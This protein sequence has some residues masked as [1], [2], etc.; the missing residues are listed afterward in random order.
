[1]VLSWPH[2]SLIPAQPRLP[3]R[4]LPVIFHRIFSRHLMHVSVLILLAMA[5]SSSLLTPAD[6]LRDPDVWWHLADA[7]ILLT[8]HH[9]IR[10]EPYAFTLAGQSWINPEWLSEVP[11]WLAYNSAGLLGIFL[12][13][14]L[15]LCAN[16]LF[17]YWRCMR[18][19][20]HSAA[21]F[22]ASVMGLVLMT[23]NT[24][25]RTILPAYLALGAEMALLE[26]AEDGKHRLLWLLPPLFCV[27]I[28]L[29]GSALVGLFLFALYIACG[30]FS[31]SMG[32]IVQSAWPSEHRRRLLTIFAASA[33]ALFINPYGWR[34]VWNP[35]DMLANQGL[36]QTFAEEWQPLSLAWYAG[37]VSVAVIVLLVIAN[38]L[39][40]RSWKIY[41]VAFVVYAWYA[42][43]AHARFT[44]FAA[45]I[46]IPLLARESAR[47]FLLP[48]DPK[49]MPAMNALFAAA[50]ACVLFV[51]FPSQS[52]LNK[53]M[54]AM[55]PMQTIA[56]L[57]PSWRIVNPDGL[58]GLLA[59]EGK[60]D[61]VDTRWDTFV[62]HGV[63][64]DYLSIK[65]LGNSLALLDQYKIDH[66]LMR[67]GE[68]L[69]YLLQRVPGWRVDR[70]EGTGDDT[71]LLFSRT[72]AA[73]PQK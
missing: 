51:Y 18:T 22:W 46:T 54:N 15:C 32:I 60:P 43:F 50:V 48:L 4:P 30:W 44:F 45:V 26:A 53:A 6:Q 47:S 7:R 67:S 35:F 23:T 8:Q 57:Q 61:F 9:F 42:A 41:E 33:A 11:I 65:F 62:H 59:F 27:W 16:I 2:R 29:H 52:S 13:S 1:M 39:R 31:F 12:F 3:H 25:P 71:C 55:Y 69:S 34:L 19:S 70:T 38:F 36:M 21:A 10:V 58:G 37:K 17:V 72:P 49:T 20:Q 66:V 28:N 56:S 14:V 73:T 5:L 64:Q 68:P 24:G 63:M 40:S